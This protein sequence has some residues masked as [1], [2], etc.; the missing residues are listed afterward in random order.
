VGARGW[1][2]GTRPTSLP[3]RFVC[4]GTSCRLLGITPRRCGEPSNS[5]QAGKTYVRRALRRAPDANFGANCQ[6]L[7]RAGSPT[8]TQAGTRG[9]MQGRNFTNF[10]ADPGRVRDLADE[11]AGIRLSPPPLVQRYLH[12][13]LPAAP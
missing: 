7:V 1:T 9:T 5:R 4:S 6:G 10:A 3:A 2:G 11:I 8:R 13:T 12:P